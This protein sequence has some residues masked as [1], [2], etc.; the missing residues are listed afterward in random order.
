M[1]IECGLTRFDSDNASGSGCGLS[2]W[3]VL[4]QADIAA[5]CRDLHGVTGQIQFADKPV[6]G[7]ISA[8][9]GV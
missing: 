2:S 5:L 3:T 6:C 9:S 1:F 4:G 7:F 8:C